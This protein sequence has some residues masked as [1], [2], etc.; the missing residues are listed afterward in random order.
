[1]RNDFVFW[2]VQKDL[3]CF[4]RQL[5]FFLDKPLKFKAKKS[6]FVEVIFGSKKVFTGSWISWIAHFEFQ[7]TSLKVKDDCLTSQTSKPAEK[8]SQMTVFFEKSLRGECVLRTTAPPLQSGY[9]MGFG[10]ARFWTRP[11]YCTSHQYKK[12]ETISGRSGRGKES[13]DF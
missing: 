13:I 2:A 12:N 6:T 9:A 11:S 8:F 4:L 7:E 3:C 10:E 5:A 1:M